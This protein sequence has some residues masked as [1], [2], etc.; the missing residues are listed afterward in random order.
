MDN[1]KRFFYGWI[2]VGA[3]AL[4]LSIGLGL[5]VSTNSVFVKPVCYSLGFARSEFTFYRTIMMLTGALVLPLFGRFIKKAGVKLTLLSGAI[6]LSSVVFCYSFANNI[7][8]IYILAFLNG[9]FSNSLNFISIGL[10]VNAWFEDKRGI[11]TGLAYAGS[12]LGGAVMIPIVSRIIELTDWRFAYRFMGVLGAVILIPVILIF[13]KNDPEKAGLTPYRS[14]KAGEDK[15]ERAVNRS[16]D[17]TLKEA[18]KTGRFWLLVAAFFMISMFGSATN[19]HSTPF[20]SDIGYPAGTV[21]A[22]ISLFMLCLT[23][24]KIILGL[25]YD[26]FGTLAGNGF[27]CVCSIIFPIAAL[28][29][30]I[31][32][33]PWVYALSVGLASCGV[34]V[35][36]SILIVKHFGFKDYPSIYSIIT[37]V[38][39]FGQSISVPVMGAAY[40]YIG[41][42]RPAWI[43][44]LVLSVILSLCLFATEV[45]Y[46]KKA[47]TVMK[48]I[49]NNR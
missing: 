30:Y 6:A 26:R 42:Y 21:S 48:V 25:I 17:L 2:I 10:L 43:V 3:S 23:V 44:L 19:T 38:A 40:D 37:M 4:I 29:A 31:P 9:I 46:R 15:K 14:P 33:F 27:V 28:L 35:P 7:W 34:S 12:G 49:E 8:H 18:L 41:S 47:A 5:F 32:V 36:V 11:A 1:R 22:I 13:I 39:T 24:G 16:F 20:L 45:I